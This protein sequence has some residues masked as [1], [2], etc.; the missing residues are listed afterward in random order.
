MS[1]A[2]RS[3]SGGEAS[4]DHI[5][6]LESDTFE[7]LVLNGEGRIAVEFMSYSC[8]HCRDMEPILQHVAASKGKEETFYR[9]NV[10][11]CSEVAEFYEIEGTPTFV[12][13]LNGNQV[14]R[15]EGPQPTIESVR[16]AVTDP[17]ESE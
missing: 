4:L 1:I 17:F 13:F 14:G 3:A 2:H 11:T 5:T 7:A 16:A 10:T 12:M 9:L 8:S 15:V 6:T